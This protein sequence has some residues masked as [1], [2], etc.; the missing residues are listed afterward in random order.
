[1]QYDRPEILD[2]MAEEFQINEKGVEKL[3]TQIYKRW[4]NEEKAN[5]E[6][7][8]KAQERR[9][10]HYIRT[11]QK[12]SDKAR[13]EKIYAKITGTEAPIKL[14]GPDGGPAKIVLEIA[15]YR[16]PEAPA[17]KKS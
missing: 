12:I 8:R 9:L 2:I 17:K 4:E 3:I 1:M 11:A 14:G 6:T 5:L 15:D 13:C 10:L 16:V 7:K